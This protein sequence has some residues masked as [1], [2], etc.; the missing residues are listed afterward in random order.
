MK[1]LQVIHQYPPHSSQGSEVYCQALAVALGASC[2]VGV[3]HTSVD[4]SA[5]RRRLR[6]EVRAGVSIFHC[7]DQ[8]HRSRA[9]EWANPFLQESFKAVLREFRPEVVHFHNY[10]SLGDPLVSIAREAGARVV[11]TLHDF[12]LI[13]PT[14]HLLMADGSIC[15]KASGDFF[16]A[17]CPD[18][19]RVGVG[20][21]SH[22]ASR[23]PSMAKWRTLAAQIPFGPGRVVMSAGVRCM[24]RLAGCGS[25]ATIGRARDFYFEATRRIFREVDLF[26]APSR[27]LRDRYIACG[28]EAER[29]RF[30][31]NG[32]Q[33]FVPA[34]KV[35][36][37]GKLRIGYIGALHAHKGIDVLLAAFEGMEERAELHVHGSTFGSEIS[38]CYWM[39]L[40][41]ETRAS[42]QVHGRYPNS[43]LP[44]ILSRLDVVVVPSIWYENAPLTIQEA[45]L[46][47][48]PVIASDCGGMA[49]MIEHGR[50]GLL[51]RVADATALRAA[52][53]RLLAEGDL[54][55]R[56]EKGIGPVPSIGTQSAQVLDVY[57]ELCAGRS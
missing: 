50:N 6:R 27:F 5:W 35:A 54:L 2:A 48:V 49:E 55:G 22:L 36:R 26:L 3:F 46:A 43:D 21:A 39:K 30:L 17:C 44:R 12:G 4:G 45:Q 23:L 29:I 31:A 38:D 13:C 37:S 52:L 1:I 16:G 14:S 42:L 53:E 8:G 34:E 40:R 11:Y 19:I 7:V 56:L 32:I 20:P 25:V 18:P 9:A 47:G 15:G 24:S 10:L 51:F 41:R 57:R 28:V 33:H